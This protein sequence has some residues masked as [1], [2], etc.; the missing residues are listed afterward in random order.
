[1]PNVLANKE[2]A[3]EFIQHDARPHKLAK[4]ILGLLDDRAVREK[5][6][7]DFDAI[8]HSLGECGASDNAAKAILEEVR[9]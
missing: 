3:P 6:L 1:M 2:I 7:S 9:A 8:I 4:A 5:M